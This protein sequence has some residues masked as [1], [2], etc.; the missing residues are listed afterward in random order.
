MRTTRIALVAGAAAIVLAGYAGL[1]EAKAPETHVLAVRLP[2]G[3]VEQVRYSGDVAPTVVLV[4]EVG[5]V[6]FDPGFPFDMLD[7]ITAVMDRQ[8]EALFGPP[9]VPNA[10]GYGII[11]TR[12]GPTVC[13]RSIQITYSGN[14]QAPHVVSR[15]SGDCDSPYGEAVRAALPSVTTPQRLPGV[16]Q[17]KVDKPYQGLIHTISDRPR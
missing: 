5:P 4:P 12:S 17:A 10:S 14:G 8:A 3:Q 7:Q 16:V 2:T 1:A 6:S 11:P 13:M 9:G 15:T